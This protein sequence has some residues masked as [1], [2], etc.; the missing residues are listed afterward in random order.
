MPVSCPPRVLSTGDTVD[1]RT[2]TQPWCGHLSVSP[3]RLR[4]ASNL[5]RASQPVNICAVNSGMMRA[6]SHRRPPTHPPPRSQVQRRPPGGALGDH[7]ARR[8][9]P[10]LR[11][12]EIALNA[13]HR[14]IPRPNSLQPVEKVPG[15]AE[16]CCGLY[17]GDTRVCHPAPAQPGGRRGVA[18]T[19]WGA[20]GG[21][22][23]PSGTC[24]HCDT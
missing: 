21:H 4:P 1:K 18:G 16:R 15:T 23:V 9:S 20:G 10:A 24:Q 7:C 17:G 2:A 8:C 19:E 13:N 22:R 12:S 14:L 5:P 3:A 11:A 6:P